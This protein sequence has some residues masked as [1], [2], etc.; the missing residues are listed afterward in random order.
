MAGIGFEL[1]KLFNGKGLIQGIRACFLSMLVAIGPT[2]LCIL[3][4][5]VLLSLLGLFDRS[6]LAIHDRQFC[7]LT[8]SGIVA[9]QG[10]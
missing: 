10:V 8:L 6:L 7:S 1:K 3:M 4:M 5:T 2:L 9:G